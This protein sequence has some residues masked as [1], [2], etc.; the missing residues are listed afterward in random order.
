[1]VPQKPLYRLFICLT[2]LAGWALLTQWRGVSEGW[3]DEIGFSLM[4]GPNSSPISFRYRRIYDDP[5]RPASGYTITRLE[6]LSIACGTRPHPANPKQENL[7]A[8]YEVQYCGLISDTIIG[9]IYYR[10]GYSCPIVDDIWRLGYG[11][12]PYATKEKMPAGWARFPLHPSEGQQEILRSYGATFW[13]DPVFGP[14]AFRLLRDMQNAE[15][16]GKYAGS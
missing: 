11:T 12:W 6:F 8:K 9:G 1:M 10:S 5:A 2:A 14:Q 4:P 16:V 15:W 13:V 3:R 7:F